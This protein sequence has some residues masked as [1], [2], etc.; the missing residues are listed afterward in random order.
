MRKFAAGLFIAVVSA[1]PAGAFDRAQIL[2]SCSRPTSDACVRAVFEAA[3]QEIDQMGGASDLSD[4]AGLSAIHREGLEIA[5]R[6][7]K[8]ADDPGES[9]QLQLLQNRKDSHK[10]ALA[11]Y[12]MWVA[13]LAADQAL[14]SGGQNGCPDLANSMVP[15]ILW[16]WERLLD[17]LATVESQPPLQRFPMFF[18]VEGLEFPTLIAEYQ[19]EYGFYDDARAT[20]ERYYARADEVRKLYIPVESL[21]APSSLE[22]ALRRLE[23]SVAIKSG[24]T[25]A[26]RSHL[27]EV[28]HASDDL[29]LLVTAI[30]ET[31]DGVAPEFVSEFVARRGEALDDFGLIVLVSA[32]T[33]VDRIEEA[34]HFAD[35]MADP[36]EY[37][38]ALSGLISAQ[39]VSVPFDEVMAF[40]LANREELKNIMSV[41][42]EIGALVRAGRTDE[43]LALVEIYQGGDRA[44]S[45]LAEIIRVAPDAVSPEFLAAFLSNN[46]AALDGMDIF[47]LADALASGKRFDEAHRLI[48]DMGYDESV[49]RAISALIERGPEAMP[50]EVLSAFLSDHEDDI[51]DLDRA[52]IVRA[53]ALAGRLPE[54]RAL[55]EQI[56][57]ADPAAFALHSLVEFGGG[58]TSST[59]MATFFI[60]RHAQLSEYVRQELVLSLVRFHLIEEAKSLGLT[61]DMMGSASEALAFL[62][63]SPPDEVVASDLDAFIGSQGEALHKY[64]T[65]ELAE[66]FAEAGD[67][68]K[69]AQL[70]A[71]LPRLSARGL[72]GAD[73]AYS[74]CYSAVSPL[75]N[76]DALM[77]RLLPEVL[78]V[79][80]KDVWPCARVSGLADIGGTLNRAKSNERFGGSP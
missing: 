11:D 40:A 13:S 8:D 31:P 3:G 17:W 45:G 65:A 74:E 56:K 22:A 66:A 57:A 44:T 67:L 78:A 71:L 33:A 64:D 43:A 10:I 21:G 4:P 79:V 39:A 58:T 38:F 2:A 28:V 77:V 49:G 36:S 62:L 41:P 12:L 76:R 20:L 7:A 80:E 9:D 25:E 35:M 23:L 63:V 47:W 14:D 52:D 69:A 72:S 53:L 19:A 51:S 73:A 16:L 32:L 37:A 29:S 30:R 18:S 70:I 27:G 15:R 50:T 1:S 42:S 34:R 5:Y 26:V 60:A 55:F 59:E 61:I 24:N 68:D 46:E 6:L 48:N 75:V 54:A